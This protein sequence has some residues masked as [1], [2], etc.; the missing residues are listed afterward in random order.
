MRGL[1]ESSSNPFRS[2]HV[3]VGPSIPTLNPSS[4]LRFRQ[5]S[6]LFRLRRAV[7]YNSVED[8]RIHRG[9]NTWNRVLGIYYATITMRTIKRE[10][11]HL[12]RALY[13]LLPGRPAGDLWTK[14]PLFS[15]NPL[16]ATAFR[17]ES[18]H[19][20][21]PYITASIRRGVPPLRA[22]MADNLGMLL[23]IGSTFDSMIFR[24]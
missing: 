6:T 24:I 22:R 18:I 4:A 16:T 5:S 14:D 3:A 12:L 1:A 11:L 7:G 17:G 10:I 20:K 21:D 2:H 9:C 8:T 23:V 15:K 19:L 13:W